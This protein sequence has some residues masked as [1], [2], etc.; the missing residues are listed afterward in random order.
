MS[1]HLELLEQVLDKIAD[2]LIK[3]A[4]ATPER[5]KL[6]QKTIRNGIIKTA[7]ASAET[8]ILYQRDIKANKE[9]L[10]RSS[11]GSSG[12][13]LD[14][15][16]GN[17]ATSGGTISEIT[18]T[19]TEEGDIKFKGPAPYNSD[20]LITDLL[21]FE[22][23]DG[24]V[25][26]VN[27]SQF[28]N[29]D[30]KKSVI[31]SEQANEFLNTNIYELLSGVAT[32]QER[33][34][35]FFDEFQNL[36]GN[37]PFTVDGWPDDDGDG[38]PDMAIDYDI[39]N[40]VT[41]NP[42]SPNAYITRLNETVEQFED[43]QNESQTLESLR[44]ILNN[45]LTDIDAQEGPPQDERPE[46]V[47]QSEG[48]LKFR[49]L[50][51]GIIIRNTNSQFVNGFDVNNLKNDVAS[52]EQGDS[53]LTTGFTVTMWVRFLDKV[54]EGTLFNFGN[55]VRNE[56]PL[57]FKL[58]TIIYNE[59]QRFVRLLVYDNIGHGEGSTTETPYGG[60]YYDSHVG[61]PGSADGFTFNKNVLLDNPANLDLVHPL[62]Y[63]E[64]PVDFNEWY[65]IC[66]TY[67]PN[68][69]EINSQAGVLDADYWRNNM[70]DNGTITPD[71]YTAN[72]GYG[73]RSKVEI[74]SKN[75]LLRA[76]GYKY[77]STTGM[78]QDTAPSAT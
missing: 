30:L 20:F 16:V 38:L 44:N 43:T 57:G 70:V 31:D 68:I 74:I 60:Y 66:A 54:S 17:I 40:D 37:Y 34:N 14:Q 13:T 53:F 67:N 49:N 56:N 32:R 29:I 52:E 72:S 11:E 46:Y 25:N 62:Q 64:V 36:V 42:N 51:Q 41:Q 19:V 8:L 21:A 26:P 50:N 76:R 78:S 2:E 35:K 10:V 9:D 24:T 15:I 47:N 12:E 63:T 33:I 71:T 18:I 45:Y 77:K 1:Q 6:N 65:F 22:E 58:D 27:L 75:D 4:Y 73:N 48:Y 61:K 69:N 3:S 23:D 7:R 55:P 39:S 59:E 28:L 5:V